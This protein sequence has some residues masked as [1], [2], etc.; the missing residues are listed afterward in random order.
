MTATTD[1]SYGKVPKNETTFPLCR[2]SHGEPWQKMLI[3]IFLI[4]LYSSFQRACT[5][6]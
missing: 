5:A 2:A 6:L 1:Y 4:I 3:A